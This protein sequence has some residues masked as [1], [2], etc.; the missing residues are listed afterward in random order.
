MAKRFMHGA[1]C[2][3][4]ANARNCLQNERERASPDRRCS[5]NGVA[6]PVWARRQLM[7]P[8]HSRGARAAPT[9]EL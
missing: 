5:G 7:L 1:H 9:A 4:R 3:E 6:V 2:I 8:C